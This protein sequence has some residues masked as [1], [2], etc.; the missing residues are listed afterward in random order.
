MKECA[1]SRAQRCAKTRQRWDL[2]ADAGVRTLLRPRTG[3]LRRRLL[4]SLTHCDFLKF[5]VGFGFF[6]NMLVHHI[7]QDTNTGT[8]EKIRRGSGLLLLALLGGAMALLC[9]QAFQSHWVMWANDSQ[10]GA[11]KSA[12]ARLPDTYFGHWLDHWWIGMD[13]PATSPTV[14]AILGTVL[15]P[16]VYLA[17]FTPLTML[18]LGFSAWVLF[19]QLKF[20]PIVCVLGGLAAGLNMHCFSN[21]CWGLGSWNIS[22][23]MIF[24]AVAA[25]VTD[26]IRQTWIKAILAGLAV[27]MSVME[28]FDSGAILS[29]YAGIFT[30]F[31]CWITES[32]VP[33]RLIKTA[34][35]GGLLVAFSLLLADSTLSTLVR[36]QVSGVTGAGQTADEKKAYW[37]FATQW[38]LPKT[39]TLRV[40][41]PGIFGYRMDEFSTPPDP[42][43]A[44]LGKMG[45]WP[46]SFLQGLADKSSAYWGKVGEDPMIARLESSNPDVRAA[47]ISSMTDRAD[48]IDI[49]R[50]DHSDK[51]KSFD[52]L[53]QIRTQIVDS[54]KV[55]SQRRHS[56]N[57]EYAGVLVALFAIFALLNSF[58]PSASPYN[59]VERRMVWFWGLATLFSLMAA[60]GRFSFLYGL[61]YQL[62]GV[63]SIRNPIKFMHPFVITWVILAGYGL[64][65]FHRCYLRGPAKPAKAAQL[66]QPNRWR[67]KLTRFDLSWIIGLLLAAVGIFAACQHYAGS[68]Q[69]LVEYLTHQ[70]FQVAP[71]ALNVASAVGMAAFSIDEARW[72]VLLFALSAGVVLSVVA[73]VW[74]PRWT[75]APWTL[76]CGIMI[77]DLSRADLPWV[78]FFNYDQKYSMN[79]V[80]KV[81]M[82]KP[83][84]HRVDARLSPRG[85]YDLANDGNFAAIN[86]WWIENDFP[87]HDIQSLEIDQMPR[88]PDLDGH[89]L[90]AFPYRPGPDINFNI[91]PAARMWKLTNTRYILAAAALLPALNELGDPQ[92]QAFQIVKRFNL[93]PKP[94]LNAT[95][96]ADA[97]DL[98]PQLS[99]TGNC[100]LIEDT[101]VLPRARLYSNWLTPTNDQ[102]V[103]QTLTAPQWDPAQSV[104]VS[105]DTPV[106]PPSAAAGADPGAVS[107]ASYNPKAIKLHATAKTSAVLLYNDRTGDGWR[108]WVDGKPS[109]LLRCN[110]IMRGVFLPAGDH[111]VEFRFRP[112]VISLYVTFSAFLVGILLAAWLSWSRFAA[113]PAAKTP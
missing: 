20:A 46:K 94:G 24:L 3:A 113:K 90:S 72:F 74:A 47:A 89:Y 107:I 100:A 25:L 60:W 53:L 54:I 81:L 61:L 64:E 67:R 35:V 65:A 63:S 6:P 87:Y 86:H 111:T 84:E 40:I 19:R 5:N 91:G 32:T 75:W 93:V 36:T 14:A 13:I 80:T 85:G 43:F 109:Q 97:G 9:H 30:A 38:S 101:A 27:G 78:R 41:I 58:R 92:H 108:V 66:L 73:L 70:G 79:E 106:P 110:Y 26:S 71:A 105:S 7:M 103:L 99:D 102:A 83:Y 95:N 98:T 112:S 31:F 77:F 2:A 29:V 28:G 21:A 23:S 76:L 57:G 4:P 56:G 37:N 42:F 11:I 22:I 10:L 69:K 44:S 16:E 50:N 82:E 15:S 62:P 34:W 52:E 8:P 39:E 88:T 51:A 33:K 18:L 104:L 48:I 68:Q 55:Q 12:S 1:R 59:P 45:G 17:I 49:M 96:I